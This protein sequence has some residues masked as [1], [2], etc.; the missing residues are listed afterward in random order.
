[1]INLLRATRL[2]F[3]ENLKWENSA[4]NSIDTLSEEEDFN[5]GAFE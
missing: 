3:G 1:M 4:G 5:V 2:G